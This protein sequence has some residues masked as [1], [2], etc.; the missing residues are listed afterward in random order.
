MSDTS[1]RLLFVDDE[2]N[3]LSAL[4]RVF[5]PLGYVVYIAE[6]GEEGLEVLEREHIDLVLSD[7]RMPAMS[8]AQFLE[9]V[10][11]KWP[12]AVRI[13]LTGYA[14]IT[15]TIDAINRGEIYRYI[16]K[17]WD[18]H[19]M[20]LV[21]R[22]AL[23]RKFLEE[24]K[25]RLEELTRRQNEELKD[26]NANLE[27]KVKAR[28]EE[29]RQ[30]LSSLEKAHEQLK[31]GYLTTIQVFA[32]LMEMREGAMAGHS[33]RVAEMAHLLAKKMGLTGTEAQDVMV[34]SLLHDIGKIGLPDYLL[35]KPFSALTNEERL[36]V[37]K[38]PIKGAAALMALEQL[39]GAAKII[40]SHHERY[41]GLGF[42]EGQVGLAI[43]L[44]ARIL[45]LAND[46]DNLL[47]GHLTAKPLNKREALDFIIE[48]RGKRYDPTAV[49]VFIDTVSKMADTSPTVAEITVTPTH[50]YSGMVLTRDVISRDGLLLLAKGHV[51]DES[52]IEQLHSF[53][54]SDGKTLVVHVR[55][56]TAGK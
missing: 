35:A 2:P 56:D 30:A 25:R 28:T 27:Q 34:A 52:V 40:R 54:K 37:V 9:K 7:M 6:S 20:V 38:H 31:K 51:L 41:D 19:D 11:E 49:D 42:P 23:E 33:K 21:V 1:S 36:E 18:D 4:K 47:N 24:E 26:L 46:Y 14:D 13:L 12:A 22:Q 32:N 10:R 43:P 3:I 50:L 55:A 17:P 53:E 45:A 15:S 16:S 48:A 39:K 8:G 5:R 29:L 44:G